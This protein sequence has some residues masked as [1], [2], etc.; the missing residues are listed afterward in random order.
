[1]VEIK[2]TG[3]ELTTEGRRNLIL[4]HLRD[5]RTVRI[6]DLMDEFGLTD[7]SI[8]RDLTILEQKGLVRRVRGGAIYPNKAQQG[9]ILRERM[10][11]NIHE[12]QRI[13][14]EALHH[15]RHNDII[16]LDTGTTIL[17]MARQL[18]EALGN[19]GGFRIVTNSIPLIEE[20]GLW[21]APNLVMLG[22][23][24]LPDLG[25]T[26]GPDMV[27]QLKRFSAQSAFLG[28]DGFTRDGGITSTHPLVAEAGRM[29][30]SRAERVIVL[31]DHTKMGRA[32]FV[33]IIP[34]EE[35]DLFITDLR[36]AQEI[37]DGLRQKGVEVIQV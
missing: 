27:D 24:Y 22:G 36:A 7:T 10:E 31:A 29:M 4:E 32:G 21:A 2:S 26:V 12:K 28:C 25:A 3:G 19:A 11:Q 5:N 1:M 8:R 6:N 16:L 20:V 34:A 30:A 37:V 33:P 14:R 17:H 15:I 23:I 13:G 9:A 35:I 18:P